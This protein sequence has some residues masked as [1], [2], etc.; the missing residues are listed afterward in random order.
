MLP[1]SLPADLCPCL[2]QP[3]QPMQ[4]ERATL[5]TPAAPWGEKD[6]RGLLHRTKHILQFSHL[7]LPQTNPPHAAELPIPWNSA[8]LEMKP[9]PAPARPGHGDAAQNLQPHCSLP[10]FL[11]SR[12]EKSTGRYLV[13][14]TTSSCHAPAKSRGSSPAALR[15]QVFPLVSNS[16]ASITP[17]GPIGDCGAQSSV[18]AAPSQH[19]LCPTNTP[20]EQRTGLEQLHGA[21]Q[22]AIGLKMFTT[23][24]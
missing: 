4:A 11:P 8:G 6:G 13:I 15:Q 21:Q 3:A 14:S 1:R 16:A 19:S 24:I 2:L 12:G 23:S 20:G 10:S 5:H 18:A 9:L 7:P 22:P 17:G